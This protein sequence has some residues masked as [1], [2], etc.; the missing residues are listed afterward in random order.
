M[1][2]VKMEPRESGMDAFGVLCSSGYSNTNVR[3]EIMQ[4]AGS[5]ATANRIARLVSPSPSGSS[6]GSSPSPRA[7]GPRTARRR[8]LGAPHRRDTSD[9]D[10]DRSDAQRPGWRVVNN[11]ARPPPGPPPA[12][13]LRPDYHRP[14]VR[15]GRALTVS[16]RGIVPSEP[17][18]SP[19]PP[20]RLEPLNPAQKL[21]AEVLARHVARLGDLPGRELERAVMRAVKE[22][23]VSAADRESWDLRGCEYEAMKTDFKVTY[24]QGR[25]PRVEAMVRAKMA[26]S[27]L[28]LGVSGGLTAET[29]QSSSDSE[30]ECDCTAC[31]GDLTA[32]RVGRQCSKKTFRAGKCTFMNVRTLRFSHNDDTELFR[33]EK[34]G[35]RFNVLQTAVELL[36]GQKG[37]N[38]VPNIRVCLHDGHW[39]CFTGN[40]RLAAFRL[41]SLCAPDRFQEIPVILDKADDS[42]YKGRQYKPKFTTAMNGRLCNGRWLPIRETGEVVGRHRTTRTFG[43]DLLDLLMPAGRDKETVAQAPAPLVAAPPLDESVLSLIAVLERQPDGLLRVDDLD[44]AGE[45]ALLPDKALLDASGGLQGFCKKHIE[46][47]EWVILGMPVQGTAI[48]LRPG[49]AGARPQTTS[50][51]AISDSPGKDRISGKDGQKCGNTTTSRAE[52][53][54]SLTQQKVDEEKTSREPAGRRAKAS[55]GPRDTTSPMSPTKG[56]RPSNLEREGKTEKGDQKGEEKLAKRLRNEEIGHERTTTLDARSISLAHQPPLAKRCKVEEACARVSSTKSVEVR[57][58]PVRVEKTAGSGAGTCTPLS[59]ITNWEKTSVQATGPVDV[60]TDQLKPQNLAG[61]L[62]STLGD[63]AGS[64]RQHRCLGRSATPRR[65]REFVVVLDGADLTMKP[66]EQEAVNC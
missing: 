6:R 10:S 2:P 9:S 44:A 22:L 29:N 66:V 62:A 46:Y 57:R 52:M 15:E 59:K 50:P 33:E 49:K 4:L 39:Y 37:P 54:K 16:G 20:E 31:T 27:T 21:R 19:P 40:R 43:L 36:S 51:H 5:L 35:Y 38:L 3:T 53:Q 48:R 47:F 18:E 58:E 17:S 14:V 13:L 26:K 32:K 30:A 8:P 64:A 24:R 11:G 34:D 56:C 60:A 28:P 55:S 45:K 25:N 65:V 41:A 23:S 7:R 1:L 42:F 12:H 63:L 61:V